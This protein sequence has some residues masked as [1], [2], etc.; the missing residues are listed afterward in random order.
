MKDENIDNMID[1]SFVARFMYNLGLA[2]AEMERQGF[3]KRLEQVEKIPSEVSVKL[4]NAL[5]EF[6]EANLKAMQK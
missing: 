5:R 2:H 3:I 1:N 4:L 6:R